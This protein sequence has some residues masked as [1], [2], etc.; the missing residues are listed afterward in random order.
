MPD[1]V[2]ERPAR[3]R[4]IIERTYDGVR[5]EPAERV[6]LDVEWT[7]DALLV[8][9]DAPFHGDP[10][11]PGPPGPTDGLW[12][13]EVVELFLLA[14]PEHYLE[15]ELGPH[16]HH[17]VLELRGRRQ[18]VR[19]GLAI[20]YDAHIEGNRWQGSARLPLHYLPAGVER[21]N[22]Y[23]IHGPPP[24][25]RYLA[26]YPVPGAQPDFHRLEHFGPLD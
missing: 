24:A 6:Q 20:D 7:A 15:I 18:P 16:G 25:R 17:W 11:P 13:Y 23:A 26:H 10:P 8:S 9:I 5:A 21:G 3:L 2:A 4:W 19:S 1:T 22:G 12:S 14:P